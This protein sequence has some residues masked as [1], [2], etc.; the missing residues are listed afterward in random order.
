M[1]IR[2]KT[3]KELCDL[4]HTTEAF[5]QKF[6]FFEQVDDLIKAFYLGLGPVENHQAPSEED[7]EN[8][9][10]KQKAKKQLEALT[11]ARQT[12]AEANEVEVVSETRQH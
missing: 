4:D 12:E 11:E 3:Y 6:A 7:D 8:E 5:E 2:L 1:E 10:I 9:R